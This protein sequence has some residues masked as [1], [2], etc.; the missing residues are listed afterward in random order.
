MDR[1]TCAH[2]KSVRAAMP[3][4]PNHGFLDP[5]RLS[6]R[7]HI[8]ASQPSGS[9]DLFSAYELARLHYS[10]FDIAVQLSEVM[11]GYRYS[12]CSDH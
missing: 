5:L 12:G 11:Q 3:S 6:G 10:E 2:A 7:A 9:P 4:S 8:W 1:T